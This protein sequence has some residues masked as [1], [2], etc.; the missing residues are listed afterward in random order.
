MFKAEQSNAAVFP[1]WHPPAALERNQAAI[2]PSSVPCS[3]EPVMELF[4]YRVKSVLEKKLIIVKLSGKPAIADAV[5][6]R[7]IHNAHQITLLGESQ[8]KRFAPR[9]WGD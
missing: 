3:R 4:R 6:D 8:R 7:L 2:C 9:P 5:L 1:A